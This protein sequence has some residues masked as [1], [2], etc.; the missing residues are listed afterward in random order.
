MTERKEKIGSLTEYNHALS[1]YYKL[2]ELFAKAKINLR[3]EEKKATETGNPI[4]L[5]SAFSDISIHSIVNIL[6]LLE[7]FSLCKFIETSLIKQYSNQTSGET[8]VSLTSKICNKLISKYKKNVFS[9]MEKKYRQLLFK[10]YQKAEK[11]RYH[12][13]N[14][15][16]NGNAFSPF[17]I[18]CSW[19]GASKDIRKFVQCCPA[20]INGGAGVAKSPKPLIE[21]LTQ[22][23]YWYDDLEHFRIIRKKTNAFKLALEN[24]TESDFMYLLKQPSLEH[25]P[26]IQINA[27]KTALKAK[28]T[29][30]CMQLLKLPGF[31]TTFSSDDIRFTLSC[32]STQIKKFKKNKDEAAVTDSC[33][34]FETILNLKECTAEVLNSKDESQK[35][36]LDSAPSI[37]ASKLKEKGAKTEEE[38][39]VDNCKDILEEKKSAH[40]IKTVSFTLK[41]RYK[42]RYCDTDYSVHCYDKRNFKNKSMFNI[43]CE[44]GHLNIVKYLIENRNQYEK[45]SIS[46][47]TI[48][49]NTI[50]KRLKA[51]K[52]TVT[53][54][55][56]LNTWWYKGDGCELYEN[57]G[58]NGLMA[59]AENGRS[60]IVEYLLSLDGVGDLIPVVDSYGRTVLHFAAGSKKWRGGSIAKILQLLLTHDKCTLDAVLNLKMVHQG[61]VWHEAAG[62]TVL[63]C[64]E[65]RGRGRN[66]Y[67][68]EYKLLKQYGALTCY[69]I[70]QNAYAEAIRTGDA[71]AVHRYHEDEDTTVFITLC[72]EGKLEAIKCL[73]DN[74][75]KL[76]AGLPQDIACSNKKAFINQL[77]RCPN[78]ACENKHSGLMFAAKNGHLNVVK[79][80]L[81]LKEIDLNV[82]DNN[83]YTV[84]VY[85]CGNSV[86]EHHQEI[87]TAILNHKQCT[88][89]MINK[90]F[91][92]NNSHG[93]T[94]LDFCVQRQY[95]NKIHMNAQAELLKSKG[96][97]HSR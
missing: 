42:E 18:A 8:T 37:F 74:Y 81:S 53:D 76:K 7:P 61:N 24:N 68:P 6:E 69:E 23:S 14:N 17:L 57:D 36:I 92:A 66:K 63:G 10:A 51:R 80:L 50:A 28:K 19:K 44:L 11:E 52:M 71:C 22:E 29:S 55:I 21:M 47:R 93:Q 40:I 60:N 79:Y 56:T 35:T 45:V 20:P 9:E 33:L 25:L 62:E 84:L 83:G 41:K 95:T 90:K 58:V 86:Q 49:T 43:A 54:F 94:V 31:D 67:N 75:N 27:F 96:A 13:F 5:Y 3:I 48:P 34:L 64:L 97:K 70:E 26:W 4:L 91:Y 78:Y 85:I 82:V 39:F 2:K 12:R 72:V 38:L 65:S 30:I 46:A 32:L 59:A 15:F 87:L 88:L 73:Y 16:F 1:E 77:G 89:A